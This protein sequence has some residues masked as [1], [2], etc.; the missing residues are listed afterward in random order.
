M[1]LN[2]GPLFKF[3]EAISMFVSVETQAEVDSLWDALLVGGEPSQ[4][5]WLKDKFGLSWQIVP[6]ALGELMGDPDPVKSQRV[7]QAM[8]KMVKLDIQGL[9]DA[10]DGR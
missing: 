4:C 8:L 9:R 3:T 5:G 1:A 2:G 6:T 7:M 10:H